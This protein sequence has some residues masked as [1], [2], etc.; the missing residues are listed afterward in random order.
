ML[1]SLA[2]LNIKPPSHHVPSPGWEYENTRIGRQGS[3]VKPFFY[4]SEREKFWYLVLELFKAGYIGSKTDGSACERVADFHALHA[5]Y[6]LDSEHQRTRK[7]EGKELGNPNHQLYH[8]TQDLVV[9]KWLGI[10]S[11][12]VYTRAQVL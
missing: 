5:L 12:L 9:E 3:I 1:D 11:P 10:L 2:E 6:C 4:S 8:T 7:E